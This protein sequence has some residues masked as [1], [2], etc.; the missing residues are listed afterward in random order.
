MFKEVMSRQDRTVR[1]CDPAYH[2]SG[3][4]YEEVTRLLQGY[5]E[6]ESDLNADRSCKQECGTYQ[7]SKTYGC[8]DDELCKKQQSC[9]GNIHNCK[10]MESTME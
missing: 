7:H 3:V 5:I 4:T 10:Y 8:K 2:R 6:N 1:R 9:T